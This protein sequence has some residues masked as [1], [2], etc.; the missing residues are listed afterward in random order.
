MKP[1]IIWRNPNTAAITGKVTRWTAREL[2]LEAKGD[3][4]QHKVLEMVVR[5]WQLR[6]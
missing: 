3:Q 2:Y 1:F 6:A 4:A 5:K